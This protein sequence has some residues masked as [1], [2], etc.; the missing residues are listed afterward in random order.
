[1]HIST[2]GAQKSSKSGGQKIS[3][4][5]SFRFEN[6]IGKQKIFKILIISAWRPFEEKVTRKHSRKRFSVIPE[7]HNP[8]I[9]SKKC[10]VS[11]GEAWVA[12]QN[13]HQEKASLNGECPSL[14]LPISQNLEIFH[15][16]NTK[17]IHLTTLFLLS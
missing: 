2:Q 9:N 13:F 8:G 5:P 7:K 1:M 17:K 11:F 16:K 3:P 12:V 4:L 14:L 15:Y 10:S 6:A